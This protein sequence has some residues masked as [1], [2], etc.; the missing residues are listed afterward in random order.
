MEIQGKENMKTLTKIILHRSKLLYIFPLIFNFNILKY[1][2]M[3]RTLKEE[4]N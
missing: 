3:N 1:F 4:Q 2:E